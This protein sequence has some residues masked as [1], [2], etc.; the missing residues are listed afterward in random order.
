MLTI[1]AA[2]APLD[3]L[4]WADPDALDLLATLV[5]SAAAIPLRVIAAYRDTEVQPQHPLAVLLADLAHAGL[6]A[7]HLLTPLSREEAAPLLEGL[8]ADVEDADTALR[9]RM[10]ERAGACRFSW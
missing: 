3:D 6:A 4:Q 1:P 8:P 9:D 2:A 7:R 10:L 5:R